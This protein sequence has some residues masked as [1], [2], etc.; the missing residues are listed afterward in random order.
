MTSKFSV[1]LGLP[2][3]AS[4]LLTACGGGESP[5]PPAEQSGLIQG[6]LT[7][8][9]L[10]SSV[11]P[12]E[13]RISAPTDAST[14]A[15]SLGLPDAVTMT[16]TYKDLLLGV[17]DIF[18]GTIGD[19]CTNVSTN[20]PAELRLYPISKLM[21]NTG[22]SV[23]AADATRAAYNAKNWW[24]SDRDIS[25]SFKGNCVGLG[26]VDA[27]FDFGRGWNVLDVTYYGDHTTYVATPQPDANTPW[28]LNSGAA[29]QSLQPNVL[30][31]W[32]NSRAYQHSR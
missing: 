29:A 32:K 15:F 24:F 3:T 28:T 13:L 11:K 25:F 10:G 16:T 19:I 21:T 12:E 1:L 26:A 9:T 5:M 2:L 8:P 30:E 20:A 4:L 7:P 27:T 22:T 14:G 18:G 6:K 17:P 23:I 31:P